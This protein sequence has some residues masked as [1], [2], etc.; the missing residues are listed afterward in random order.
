MVVPRTMAMVA[1]REQGWTL[2]DIG[3]AFGLTRERVRQI[4]EMSDGPTA[5][6]F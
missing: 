1:L 2:A 4:L 5:E 6:G 3:D